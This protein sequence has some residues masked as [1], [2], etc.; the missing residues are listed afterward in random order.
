MTAYAATFSSRFK[1]LLQY[2]AAAMAGLCTQLFWGFMRVM[3]FT[4]FYASSTNAL[5]MDLQQTVS[6]IWMG[7]ALFALIPFRPDP[8][9]EKLVMSGNVAYELCRPVDLY[10]TWFS[11]CLAMRCAPVILRAIPIITVTWLFFGLDLPDSTTQLL[12]FSVSSV[13]SMFLSASITMIT[14]LLIFTTLSN[15]ANLIVATLTLFFAGIIIPVPLFPD[16]MQQAV[17]IL[18]FRGIIDTP[19]RL[20]MN[21][22]N[23]EQAIYYLGHQFIWVF[24][25]VLLGRMYLSH[26]IRKT[27]VQGG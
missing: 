1:A 13:L 9:I 24:I 8:D 27:V 7:Q 15:Q 23:S 10:W 21:H 4:A 17:H 11:R 26:A 12:A 22:V 3:I 2:R 19:I 5:P 14:C 20:F 18:P 6:Y 16:W 25:I